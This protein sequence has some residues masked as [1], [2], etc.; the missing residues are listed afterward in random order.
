MSDRKSNPLLLDA[1]EA[2][3][4]R[5]VLETH[6]LFYYVSSL[7]MLRRHCDSFED[8]QRIVANT[9]VSQIVV[10]A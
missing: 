2:K 10:K 8:A 1:A 4:A 6:E 5:L 7:T 3:V 9:G